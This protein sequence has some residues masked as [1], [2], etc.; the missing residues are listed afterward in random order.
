MIRSGPKEEPSGHLPNRA[1][2]GQRNFSQGQHPRLETGFERKVN[3]VRLKLR[4][5]KNV[6]AKDSRKARRKSSL[7]ISMPITS[8]AA[9]AANAAR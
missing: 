7:P 6:A 9:A 3:A 5:T 8:A 4:K 1:E 2:T